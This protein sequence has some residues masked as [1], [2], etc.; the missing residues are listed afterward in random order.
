MDLLGQ[1]PYLLV[2]ARLQ[3]GRLDEFLLWNRQVYV[4]RMLAVPGIERALRMSMARGKSESAT[5][6]VFENDA[7]VKR[8]LSSTEAASA[9]AGWD[10]WMP[11]V[12]DLSIQ[13]YSA[14]S[15]RFLP[16]SWN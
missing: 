8:A 15:P 16:F 6:F 14:L 1:Q 11:F 4:P 13:I 3:P 9:R 5:I 12:R 2:R 10:A 7:V